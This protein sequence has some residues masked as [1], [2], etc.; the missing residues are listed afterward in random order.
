MFDK[1]DKSVSLSVSQ[2]YINYWSVLNE[3]DNEMSASVLRPDVAQILLA[4]VREKP[5]IFSQPQVCC[6]CVI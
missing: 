4:E 1:I 6:A 3:S 5:C 2:S